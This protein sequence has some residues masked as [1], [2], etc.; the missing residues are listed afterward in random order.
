[1]KPTL[2]CRF[3]IRAYVSHPDS[4]VPVQRAIRAAYYRGGTSRAVIFHTRDLPWDRRVWPGIFQQLMGSGDPYGRQLDGMGAGISSLSKICLVEKYREEKL[5]EGKNNTFHAEERIHDGEATEPAHVDYT[6]VGLGIENDEVDVAGNC[7]NMSSAI[8]PYAYNARLL[9]REMYVKADGEVTVKIRNT[10]TGKFIDSTFRVVRRQAAVTGDYSIDGV[11]GRGSKIQLDFRSPYGSKTGKV[12]PTGRRVDTIAG[13]KVTCVDGANPA[14]FI[15]ADDIGVDGTILPNDFN[16]LPDKLDLLEKIRKSAAVAMGIAKTE[17]EAPRTIPKIGIVSMSQTHTVLSGATLKTSQMDLVVRFISDTQP[18]RAVPLTAALTTAVAARIPGT[19][20]EQ[21]L[22]PDP[23]MEDAI[24]IGHASGRLQVNAAMDPKNPLNPLSATVYRTA[25]RLF[26]GNMYW[27]PEVEPV[28]SL[29]V[30]TLNRLSLGMAFVTE[31]RDQSH[32]YPTETTVQQHEESNHTGDYVAPF[33][34]DSQSEPGFDCQP[35]YTRLERTDDP[36]PRSK[37][38]LSHQL[39]EAV[40]PRD[41]RPGPKPQATTPESPPDELARHPYRGTIAERPAPPQLSPASHREATWPHFSHSRSQSHSQSRDAPDAASIRERGTQ[42][43]NLHARIKEREIGVT[44]AKI[45]A[46]YEVGGDGAATTS[47]PQPRESGPN[48][49]RLTYQIKAV[50]EQIE[51]YKKHLTTLLAARRHE[52]AHPSTIASSLPPPSSPSEPSVPSTPSQ[53]THYF[54]A[55]TEEKGREF[56]GW[57]RDFAKRKA[58]WRQRVEKSEVK[59]ERRAVMKERRR[60]W[61][62]DKA[63]NIKRRLGGGTE[64]VRGAV[65]K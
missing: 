4:S 21:L 13:Y 55:S 49:K 26:E 33:L 5:F 14:V 45:N 42:S 59:A 56:H 6:F 9:P 1:M 27:V 10:N 53:A 8:G 24:T 63:G 22:A 12:L 16:K 50:K 28:E 38:M 35:L 48:T 37:L 46:E 54:P 61:G 36:V 39:Y 31:S 3:S 25:K 17:D 19:I 47:T 41:T 11:T 30:K 44:P 2:P 58:G 51:L 65:G 32:I 40:S 23:V 20:V 62:L 43:Q 15:R 57:A 7:G 18:H 29:S 60:W 34:D 64:T 52:I